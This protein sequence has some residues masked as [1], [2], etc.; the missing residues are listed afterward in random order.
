MPNSTAKTN[1]EQNNDSLQKKWIAEELGALKDLVE[2]TKKIEERVNNQKNNTETV[3]EKEKREADEM[4]KKLEKTEKQA[5][6]LEKKN[7]P[8]TKKNWPEKKQEKSQPRKTPVKY[9]AKINPKKIENRRNKKEMIASVKRVE[10]LVNQ[11]DNFFSRIAK[12][13]VN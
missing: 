2:W 6:K 1:A 12:K 7:T 9:Q 8:E 11:E 3:E 10:D 5:E 13:I 4:I